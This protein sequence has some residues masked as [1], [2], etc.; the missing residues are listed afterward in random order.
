VISDAAKL[1]ISFSL[2]LQPSTAASA[3]GEI[4]VFVGNFLCSLAAQSII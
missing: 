3:S 1:R 2:R 4:A